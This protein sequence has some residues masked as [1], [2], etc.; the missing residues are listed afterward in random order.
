MRKLGKVIVL[1][2][3]LLF[4]G[5]TVPIVPLGTQ[6]AEAASIV[7]ISKTTF[8]TKA[9]LRL[10]SGASTKYKTIKIIPKGKT[11]I[12]S[13]KMGRWY[14]V[15]YT[16][17]SSGKN[18][19]KTGWVSGSYLKKSTPVVNIV[20]FPKTFYTTIGNLRMYSNAGTHYQTI[21]TIPKGKVVFSSEKIGSWYKASYTY[22]LKGK[23]VTK[24][25]WVS[26][27]Y[28][29]EYYQYIKF[30]GTH[31]F[32][33]KTAYFYTTPDRKNKAYT[34][35]VSN[36]GFY[37]NEKVINSLGQTWYRVSYKGKTL[38]VYSDD[39][40]RYASKNFLKT[41]FK[42]NKDTYIYSSYGLGYSKSK[43]KK[44]TIVSSTS[45]LQD[46]YK[47]MY[48]G[49]SGYI[50]AKDFTRYTPIRTVTET[51]VSGRTFLTKGDVNLKI[52]A[53]PSSDT[54]LVVPN[55]KMVNPS[56]I[57]SNG[58]YKFSYSGKTGYVSG[59]D[60]N[61]VIKGATFNRDSYQFLDLR[62]QSP[63][64]A[65]QINNYIANYIKLN[66]KNS[67][68]LGKGQAF[69]NAGKKYGVNS[70]YLAAHAIHESG[71]GTSNI[72]YGKR[73]LFGF[74]AYD[75]NPFVSAYR[76]ATID[77]SIDYIAQEIKATYLNPLSW[78]FN[79]AYLGY[80]TKDLHNKR[81]DEYSG[82]MNFYYASDSNWGNSIAAHMQK[83]LPYNK[84]DYLNKKPN[85]TMYSQPAIPSG[86]DIFP[87]GIQAVVKYKDGL[88]L[89]DSKGDKT[90][91]SKIITK[92]SKFILLEKRN[93]FWIKVKVG[94]KV[95]WTNDIHFDIYNDYIAVQNLARVV[96]SGLNVRPEAST[97]KEP[98]SVLG[99]NTYIQLLIDKDGKQIMDSSKSWNK[100]RLSNGK[101]G[102]VSSKFIS[103]ELK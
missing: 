101:T 98:I 20:K 80:T 25:G 48:N 4:G 102:W 11:V 41:S 45:S 44:G 91:V 33:K 49:K 100:I 95:Y 9:N 57:T 70:L 26:N 96:T 92:D 74:G 22:N 99:L 50:Q 85:L 42:A 37:S 62:I 103:I 75:S 53:D 7:K 82:G 14:M 67:I 60:L 23:Q 35:F 21:F 28:L 1:S 27:G 97:N 3:G 17:K 15:S 71:F 73:N 90:K 63:V 10:R 61:Q 12:T 55:N 19:T 64:T 13:Q 78:K 43:I 77:Q 54:L 81:I 32:T 94:D 88:N 66:Q 87:A 58:W 24:T 31:Y 52:Y 5:V 8:Q 86:S 18:I 69:I 68:L 79:G 72:S 46:W 2:V 30:S 84:N 36:T 89:Y 76:F 56:A 34:R 29:K 51:P 6:Q 65:T 38:Y 93:D 39:V 40:V 83:I 59:T 16:Y 47:V